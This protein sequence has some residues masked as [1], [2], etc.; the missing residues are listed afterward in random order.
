VVDVE[1]DAVLTAAP[2]AVGAPEVISSKDVESEPGSHGKH[3]S[4]KLDRSFS[5]TR[6]A[7]P[8]WS[9]DAARGL[10]LVRVVVVLL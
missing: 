3:R 7:K 5:P 2:D 6:R 8:I 4:F 9:C 1:N 10:L